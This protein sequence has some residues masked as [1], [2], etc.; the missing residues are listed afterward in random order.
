[1]INHNLLIVAS[2]KVIAANSVV[3]NVT[4]D[5]FLLYQDM[6]MMPKNWHMPLVLFLST[7]QPPKLASK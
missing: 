7:L 4:E 5:C 3:D 6:S 2:S 1:M